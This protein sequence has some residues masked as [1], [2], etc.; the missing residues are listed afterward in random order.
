MTIVVVGGGG[1]GL[2]VAG[3][4][5]QSSQRVALLARP[6]T[7]QA[8]RAQG[9]HIAQG[10]EVQHL[11]APPAAAEPA[12]LPPDYQQPDLAIL[13]VKGYDTAAALATLH[14]LRPGQVLT[15][16]N[17]IG[18]EEMLAAQLGAASVLSG[19]ITTS[20]QVESP[21]HITL[22]K[23][24]G[25]GLAPVQERSS[26]IVWGAVLGRA[27]F[28]VR[29][30]ADYRA[31]KWSKALLNMLGNAV[32]AILDMSIE[33]VYANRPL[34]E[35]ERQ[36]FLEALHVMQR[37]HIRPLNLPAYPVALLAT[38]VRVLPPVA[39]FPLLR[40][41]VAGGRGGKL[42]SL[43]AD[44]RQGRAASEG[45]SLYGAV[46]QSAQACGLTAP[47][48]AAIWQTLDGIVSGAIAWQTFRQRPD[49]LLAVVQRSLA[50]SS[51]PLTDKET[52]S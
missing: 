33:A 15:L 42:P 35:L 37:R 11:E 32:P 25:I 5:A 3:R 19:A 17:G 38:A 9:L 39:L 20:V 36:V 27:G 18:N 50:E 14:A 44:L 43:H 40:R 26:V 29:T 34:I 47:V 13:C 51:H 48:N 52:T 30:Y 22:T 8:L 49:Q 46:A 16:Q 28:A 6:G 10:G 7:V 41:L 23:V 4:L 12:D 21:A 24:G 2:L 31:L 1:I 45:S